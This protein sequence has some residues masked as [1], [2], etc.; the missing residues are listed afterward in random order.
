V[1]ATKDCHNEFTAEYEHEE[2]L[3]EHYSAKTALNLHSFLVLEAGN[4]SWK[5]H[6]V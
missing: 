1:S 2:T 6:S 4:V 5:M 3:R